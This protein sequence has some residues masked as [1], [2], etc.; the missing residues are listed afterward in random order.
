MFQ[1]SQE[2]DNQLTVVADDRTP[3][4]PL[5]SPCK[6]IQQCNFA[7]KSAAVTKAGDDI[8]RAADQDDNDDNSDNEKKK[9]QFQ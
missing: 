7:V 8:E 3:E 4:S 6:L 1:Q 9:P 2:L 5:P